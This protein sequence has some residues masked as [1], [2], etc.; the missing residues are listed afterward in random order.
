M[1]DL[2]Q[3]PPD[4]VVKAASIAALTTDPSLVV[5]LSPNSPVALPVLTKGTQGASGV[6][7]QDLI[8][9]GRSIRTITLDSFAVVAVTETLNTMSY[10]SDNGTP[11]TGTSY[12]VTAGKR[13]RIQQI[14]L[15]LHTITGNTVGVTVIV[16]IRALAPGPAT[17]TSNVQLVIP[18]TGSAAA[19]MATVAVVVPIPDGWEFVAG[20]GIGITTTCAGFVAT[21]AAPKVDISIIGFEY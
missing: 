7:T 6:M 20:T 16:R 14:T 5:A 19:N 11:T 17:I 13:L 12:A 21:T 1:A 10:S 15:A 8:D 3:Q 4:Q 2:R 9:S 18:I